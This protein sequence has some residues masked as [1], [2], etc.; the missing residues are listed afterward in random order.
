MPHGQVVRIASAMEIIDSS[1]LC[2]LA[3]FVVVGWLLAVRTGGPFH[4]AAVAAA[5]F[6]PVA[7]FGLFCSLAI[8][9]R[10]FDGWPRVIGYEGFPPA[11]VAHGQIALFAFETLLLGSLFVWPVAV[12][13]C[14]LVPRMRPALRYLGVYA[15]TGGMAVGAMLLA[16]D[17]FLYWWMD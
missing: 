1:I 15:C 6:H 2:S 10:R 4:R 9:M 14:A 11:L 5:A 3:S 13:L 16:P 17:P 12:L 8:H 7:S